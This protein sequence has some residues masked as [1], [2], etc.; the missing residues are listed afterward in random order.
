MTAA[1]AVDAAAVSGAA[2][3]AAVAAAGA[4]SLAAAGSCWPLMLLWSDL[5]ACRGTCEVCCYAASLSFNYSP[6]PLL[7]RACLE[8]A[9]QVACW[10]DRADLCTCG[11]LTGCGAI[12]LHRHR[13]LQRR[14]RDILS[15][16]TRPWKSFAHC[17]MNLCALWNIQCWASTWQSL[18]PMSGPHASQRLVFLIL[19]KHA[20]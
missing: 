13:L 6:S 17:A 9:V 2:T 14:M 18:M 7:C 12:G 8:R 3:S 20:W 10:S 1:A 11:R 4:A 16:V 19:A 5:F 15:K